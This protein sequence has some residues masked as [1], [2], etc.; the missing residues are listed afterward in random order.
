MYEK[1]TKCPNFTLF[2]PEK[3]AK[4]PNLWYL[5]EKLTKFPI[6]AWFCPKNARIFHKNWRKIFS[7]IFFLGG[8]GG[9]DEVAPAFFA[10]EYIHIFIWAG[11]LA[12]VNILLCC[13]GCLLNVTRRVESTTWR[14]VMCCLRRRR[15]AACVCGWVCHAACGLLKLIRMSASW[16]VMTQAV[17]CGTGKYHSVL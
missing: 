2:L 17:V 10:F 6:F 1:L 3:V 12:L 9:R 14:D 8:G 15:D 7:P 16:R 5:P 11:R 13:V 4:Y